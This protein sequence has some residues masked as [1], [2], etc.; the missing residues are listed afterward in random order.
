MP[1]NVRYFV[2]V[3]PDSGHSIGGA[4][5]DIN[6]L[7]ATAKV[8]SFPLPTAQISVFVFDDSIP[9][10]NEPDVALFVQGGLETG[11]PGFSV[12]VFDQAGQMMQDAF[13]NPLGT[14]YQQNPDGSFVLDA[15]G[16]PVVDMMGNSVILTDANGQAT[17][18]YL[19][20]GK[21]GIR[22]VPP[23]GQEWFQTSTIE[24]TPGI[25]TWVKSN[26]PQFLVEFG[27]PFPTRIHR[28]YSKKSSCDAR[29]QRYN[30]HGNRKD[31]NEPFTSSAGCNYLFRTAGAGCIRWSKYNSDGNAGMYI[32]REVQC[33]Q[34]V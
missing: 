10:N 22:V 29:P 26:E 30:R 6:Q 13:A 16:V 28:I 34:H 32:C 9:L 4:S 20:P 11:L 14:T 23:Q 25:D 19:A 18:K 31:Y 5:V 2:S 12:L 7:T 24:G 8:N 21:Y 3:L 17:V 27:P 33:R 15:D 1:T